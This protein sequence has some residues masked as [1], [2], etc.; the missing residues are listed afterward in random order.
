MLGLS[1]FI[2]NSQTSIL[3]HEY[4]PSVHVQRIMDQRHS[5]ELSNHDIG[6]PG[7]CQHCSVP[8]D[9]EIEPGY[10]KETK[11]RLTRKSLDKYIQ[12]ADEGHIV[13]NVTHWVEGRWPNLYMIT[14]QHV[15]ACRDCVMRRF[16]RWHDRVISDE[17][18]QV[19]QML[20]HLDMIRDGYSNISKV[21][22]A[23]PIY[24]Y[25]PRP[26]TWIHIYNRTWKTGV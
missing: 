16:D 20:V 10:Y 15:P 21:K 4:E 25:I 2:T 8:V 22:H 5:D 1:E 26:S 19:H 24:S 23:E 13:E 3:E 9:S 6:T 7:T 12:L 11:E 14:E 18:K 17:D